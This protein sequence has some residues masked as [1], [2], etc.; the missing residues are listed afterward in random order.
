[1]WNQSELRPLE[2]FVFALTPFN[3]TAIGGNLPTAPALMG[4]TVVWKPAETQV[5]AAWRTMQIL[6]EAGFPPGVINFIPG[7]PHDQTNVLLDHPD[8]AGVHF[9]GSTDVFHSFWSGSPT[10]SIAT[11]RTRGS[12]AR[13]AARTSCS[14]TR[15]RIR[16]RSRPRSIRGGYEYQGQKCSAASRAYIAES[17]WDAMKDE[18]IETINSLR[19]G[20]VSDFTNFCGA[21]IKKGAFD[22]HATAIAEARETRGMK[23]VAGG[24][25]DDREGYFVKPT[26]I[27]TEDPMVRHMQEELFGPIVTLHVYPDQRVGR[28]AAPRRQDVAVRADRRGVRARPRGDRARVE[29]RCAMRPATSTSTTSRPARSS[30]SSRSAARARRAPTTRPARC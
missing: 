4:N 16:R 26:L 10:T 15:R 20:D 11:A 8:L 23:V 14:R 3:F 12:S 7:L 9:T 22:K 19:V 27:T 17:V 1:M 13:P 21:V 30:A 28:H 2:G 18:L 29:T 24:G 5:L 25:T 6:E